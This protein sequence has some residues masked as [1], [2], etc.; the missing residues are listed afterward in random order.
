MR[1]VRRPAVRARRNRWLRVAGLLAVLSLFGVLLTS[2]AAVL[3]PSGF[4]GNDG[5]MVVGGNPVPPGNGT[6]DWA[7]VSPTVI[8]DGSGAGDVSITG[9]ANGG[10]EDVPYPFL[11]TGNVPPKNDLLTIGIATEQVGGK[12][13]LYASSI[14]AAPNGSANLNFELNK[15]TN[16]VS[17]NELTPNRVAGDKLL[18]FDFTSGGTKAE[19]NLLTWKTS[20]TCLEAPAPPCWG[21]IVDLDASLVA[22]GAANDGLLGRTGAIATGGNTLSTGALAANVFQEMS[23]NLTDAGILPSSG[24]GTCTT[25]AYVTTKSRTSG[26]SFLSSLKDINVANRPISNCGSIV[27]TKTDDAGNP[28]SGVEFKLYKNAAPLTAP[29]GAEDTLTNPLKSCTTGAD[30][31]CTIS[32]VFFGTYWVVE[33]AAPAGHTAA[34]DQAVS[35]SGTTA[36]QL[37]FVNA[38]Q[39]GSVSIHKQD[40]AATAMQGV[41]FKLYNDAAPTGGTRGAEDTVTN[42]LLSCTT[43][44]AGD[45]TISSVPLGRY[46]VVEDTSTLPAGYTAAADQNVN[47]TTGGQSV[48]L[49]FTNP[50]THRVLVIVCHEGNART[51]KPSDVTVGATTKSSITAADLPAGVTEQQL[52]DMGGATR[53]FRGLGHGT[54]SASIAVATH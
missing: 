2:A 54:V 47:I 19:I 22:E 43:D 34:A 37:T 49:T 45:C 48:P 4:E 39:P 32:D 28:L 50:R 31:K 30:G 26:N 7:N 51:L 23:V 36:V 40:D 52:C 13:F 14:R 10:K 16:G 25:F 41:T 42:P 35:V 17:P 6:K 29:R 3:A 18:T 8:T 38:R 12:D 21:D 53:S 1:E 20:G 46:W 24:T 5:N 33:T 44:A 11:T 27:I 15:G 9:G